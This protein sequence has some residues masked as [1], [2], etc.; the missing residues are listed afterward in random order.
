MQYARKMAESSWGPGLWW[1]G[2]EDIRIRMADEDMIAMTGIVMTVIVMIDVIAMTEMTGVAEMTDTHDGGHTLVLRHV[3]KG[4]ADP[5]PDPGAD[6]ILNQDPDL[7]CQTEIAATA[8]IE[9][10]V[11]AE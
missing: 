2:P 1:S 3:I 8:V 11:A 5:H 4:V 10:E 6:L 7:P 9:A